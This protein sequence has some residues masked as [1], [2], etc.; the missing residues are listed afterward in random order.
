MGIAIGGTI[1]QNVLL[2]DLPQAFVDTLPDGVAIAYAVIP[3]IPTLEEPL[4]REVQRAFANAVQLLWRVMIGVSGVGLLTCALMK[5]E[6]LRTDMDE[7][8]GL[9]ERVRGKTMSGEEGED[10]SSSLSR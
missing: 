2:R 1:I 10:Q 7:T 5:E 8:W 4:K 9:Q 3:S 6:S